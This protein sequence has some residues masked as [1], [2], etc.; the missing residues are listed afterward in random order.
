LPEEITLQT[1][2][3]YLEAY[4]LLTGKEFENS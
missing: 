4:R 3:R 2:E 1:R